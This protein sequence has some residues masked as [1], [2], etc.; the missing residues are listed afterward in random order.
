MILDGNHSRKRIR[1][2]QLIESWGPGGAE[3]VVVD[4][5]TRLDLAVFSPLV[6]LMHTGWL[7]DQ[8]RAHGIEVILID[9]LHSFDPA[10]LWRLVRV[11]RGYRVDIVHGHEFTMNIYGAMAAFLTGKVSLAT[12]HGTGYYPDKGRRRGAYRLV[13]AL[14]NS[15]LITVS[16]FLRDF[17]CAKTGVSPAKIRT[18]ANGVDFSRFNGATMPRTERSNQ[19]PRIGTL[20][21]LYPVKGHIFLI[22]AA[23]LV[24]KQHPGAI[25]V[26]AGKDT[27]YRREL[28]AEA[29]KLGVDRHLQFLPFQEDVPSFLS[30]LDL[31][32][33]PSLQETFSIALIE[34]MA[35]GL[36]V[37]S[38][39]C[40]GPEEL[41]VDGRNGYLVQPEDEELLADKINQ[42]LTNR[43]QARRFGE[44]GQELAAKKFGLGKMIAAYQEVYGTLA[45][46]KGD[47]RNERQIHHSFVRK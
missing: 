12:V 47:N 21:S 45:S 31:F 39:R 10:L 35:A 11:I 6:G 20:G 41:V 22:R 18:I 28:Q 8:L 9:N 42:L 2:L 5:A 16:L 33:L 44:N 25:F 13:A 29:E 36:P 19:R 26:I 34:A 1:V 46:R 15:Q 7:H 17:F 27:P 38:T 30:S 32:V 14:P 23:H 4:L 3:K 40:G 24:L 37:I 43:E